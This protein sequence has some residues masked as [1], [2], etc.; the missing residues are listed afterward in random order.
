MA[1]WVETATRNTAAAKM[2]R[3]CITPQRR[4]AIADWLRDNG[5]ASGATVARALTLHNSVV[6]RILRNSD[7]VFAMMENGHYDIHRNIVV[8][9]VPRSVTHPAGSPWW[10]TFDLVEFD[11][12]E[13]FIGGCE[14]AKCVRYHSAME[15]A[16][17]QR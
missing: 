2:N 15:V 12:V 10:W 17:G 7:D 13:M 8:R 1:S 3:N 6:Y 5:P 9:R 16:G 14:A 4:M 11:G